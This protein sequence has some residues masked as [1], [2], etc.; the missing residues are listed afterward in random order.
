[1][2]VLGL[3]FDSAICGV[4]MSHSPLLV[5]LSFL[6]AILASY[7]SL[8]MAERMREA[9]GATRRYWL[10][11]AGLSL[12]AG[13]WS[14]HF[15]AM[16]A[17]DLPIEQGY[18]PIAT[19][20]SGLVAVG[21]VIAG[22]AFL[23]RTPS[24]ARLVAAGVIVGSGVVVMHYLG[25]SAMRVAGEVSYRPGLFSLSVLIALTAATVALWLA[26]N[27]KSFV[28][29]VVAS[30]VMAV[31]ICGMH[32]TGMAGTVVVALPMMAP[33]ADLVSK[34]MLAIVVAI[35]MAGLV[36]TGLVLAHFD[37][38]MDA[39]AVAEAARLREVN[40]KL[41]EARQRAE[42]AA[43]AES[44]FLATMSHEIRTPMNGVIGMIE[45]A[46]GASR[47]DTEVREYLTT[48]RSSAEGL[49]RILNDI[50]DYSKLESGQ[51]EIESAP[52]SLSSLIDEV[53]STHGLVAREKG[54]GLKVRIDERLPEWIAGDALRLKQ[55]L[56][57]Y[58]SNAVKFTA[59]G[60]IEVV[61]RYIDR[62]QGHVR[63]EV[64]DTGIGFD[65][66]TRERLF[67]RFVQADASTTRKFGGTGLGL[68]ICRELAASMGG[69]VGCSSE[70]GRGSVFW[71][72]VPA[73]ACAAPEL[74]TAAHDTGIRFERPLRLLV[75]EDNPVNQKVVRV[76]LG[77]RG[78]DLNFANNG[79]EALEAVQRDS[80]DMVFMDVQMPEMDGV[81]A[82]QRIRELDGP[83]GQ[84]PIIALTANAMAGDRESY[85]AAG[86]D[87]YVSKPL[88]IKQVMA[89]IA[90][91]AP[92]SL[93]RV[94]DSSD[95]EISVAADEK[96]DAGSAKMPGGG[97]DSLQDLIGDIDDIVA[98]FKA[99]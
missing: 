74:D 21:A 39:A 24:I 91:N 71:L 68:A 63:I 69:E 86:M 89:A 16:V 52:L 10:G 76:L 43:R 59:E 77:H 67:K 26:I 34:E 61:A 56:T 81:E 42:A 51:L 20:I 48:A 22:L 15:I 29:R 64:H 19:V 78:H 47:L 8:D 41:E 35:G 98:G 83:A 80:F 99:G 11:F 17:L 88:Q 12:G 14:M 75:A 57:N 79:R 55:M 53:I 37:R 94:Q 23:G 65:E 5:G 2:N 3:T 32:Y 13:I 82:T 27:L 31:A 97:A 73:P 92:V 9:D 72:V 45:G 54:I 46:L 84:I 36:V 33:P 66:E 95:A 90:R 62:D 58:V 38:K 4:E 28:H 44:Q 87:D 50:L 18:E 60:Q 96:A 40:A 49:L 70:M 7:C 6:I 30:G 1:M 93:R 25:M 85:L